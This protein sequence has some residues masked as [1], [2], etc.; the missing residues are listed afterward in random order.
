MD[1][2]IVLIGALAGF[3][4]VAMGAFAAHALA[5]QIA[6]VA[7]GWIDTGARYGAIH[8]VA[9]LV[10]ALLAAR[11]PGRPI[12]LRIAAAGFVAGSVLFSG[13]LY[14]MGLSGSR[15]M[16][17]VVPVG[18]LGFLVGWLSLAAY[19]LDRGDAGSVP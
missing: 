17:G 15:A 12:A 11:Q 14:V 9:L 13:T 6:P 4:A 5:G 1:R 7:L 2:W 19:A 8:A 3:A 18:G 10:V 16:A